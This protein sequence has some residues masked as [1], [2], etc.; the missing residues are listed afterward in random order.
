MWLQK[1]HPDKCH[2]LTVGKFEN[3]KY[4]H[5]YKVGGKEIEHVFDEKDLGVVVD[6]E[7]AFAEHITEK[8]KKANSIIGIIRRSFSCLDKDTFV[9]LF[10][11]FVRHHLEYVQVIWSLHLRKY[12]KMIENVQ[13]QA[14][15]LVNGFGKLSY[16]ERLEKLKLPTLAFRRLR[17]DMIETYKHFHTYDPSTLPKS[18]RPRTRPSRSHQYQIHPI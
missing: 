12:I 14:T 15:K 2:L 9:K 13:I 18:F 17:G 16:S 6:S 1:F 11:T 8:V 4:C 3:I 10:T 5:R 7:L